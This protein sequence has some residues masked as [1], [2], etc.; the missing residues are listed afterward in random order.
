MAT[1]VE[2]N[3]NAPFSI[4]TTPIYRE[5]R[6]SFPWIAL[7]ILDTY[8]I[9]LS[10]S[11][12]VSSTI[13]KVFGMTRPGIKPRSPDSWRTLYPL[14]QWVSR[15]KSFLILLILDLN[16]S[17]F[18]PKRKKKQTKYCR[19][20]IVERPNIKLLEWVKSF[21]V[22]HNSPVPD[23]LP[24]REGDEPHWTLKF[25]ACLILSKYN[26][27]DLLLTLGTWHSFKLTWLYMTVKA[28]A[29]RTNYSI[30]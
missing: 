21:K 8:L 29:N 2:G 20:L 5:G 24:A 12:E 19:S 1:V 16:C 10:V 4:A 23:A 14:D 11:K 7:F 13:F 9:L 17:K 25:R 27:L 28:F 26:P 22:K 6:Y 15:K 3:Q 18:I 30:L